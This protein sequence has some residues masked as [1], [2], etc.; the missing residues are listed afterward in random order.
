MA[1][2]LP[3]VF[4]IV[5]G[6][7]F[8]ETLA[9]AVLQGFPNGETTRPLSD[10]TIL[11]PSR[12]AASAFTEILLAKSGKRALILP[13]VKPIGDLDEDRLQDEMMSGDFPEA[14]PALATLL[15]LTRLVKVWATHNPAIHLAQEI[16]ASPVQALNLAR[17]L[18]DIIITAETHHLGASDLAKLYDIDVAEHRQTITSLLELVLK[19]LPSLQVAE[20]KMG[21][22]ARRGAMI[23]A[24]A[25]RIA[26]D[27]HAGPIIAAGS[28]GSI[29][30]TRELL[31]AIA[32]HAE[33]AVIL[34][35]LDQ[36]SDED[37]WKAIKPEHPQFALKTLMA[38]LGIL[39]KDVQ[40]LGPIS[41]P[42]LPLLSEIFRPT[43]TTPEWHKKLPALRDQMAAGLS[44]VTEI[45]SPD[46]HLEARAIAL[47]M[48]ETL[49]HKNKTA[50]LITPDRDL[51]QRVVVELQ[52]WKITVFDS[53]G[54][55][56]VRR[57]LGAA[58]DLFLQV[59]LKEF[60]P[61]A[62][63]A[64]LRHPLVNLG[65]PPETYSRLVE[66]FELAAFRGPVVKLESY[67]A[68]LTQ[69]RSRAENNIHIHPAIKALTPE[70][71][72]ALK[73]LAV[74][75]DHL[76]T[77]SSHH[78]AGIAAQLLA[79]ENALRFAVKPEAWTD[80]SSGVIELLADLKVE[81]HRRPDASVGE[82][83]LLLRQLLQTETQ[84]PAGNGH[85]RLAILGTIEARLLPFEVII[86]GGLN[87]TVWPKGA[88]PG[89]WLNRS[90]REKL[91]LPLPERDLGMAAHDFEQGF[92]AKEIYLTWSKRL[93]HAPQSPS[94]WL[95]R[96][97]AVLVASGVAP[98]EAGDWLALA[99]SL[100]Q[101]GA[102]DPV[103]KPSFAPPLSARPTRFSV[104]EVEKLIRNPYAIYAK[105]ILKLEPLPEF[106]EAPHAGLRGSLFHD[107]IGN[108]NAAQS[109]SLESILAEGEKAL[110]TLG[111][112]EEKRFWLPHFKR[113]AAFLWAEQE[114]LK[115]DLL[116][117]RAELDGKLEFKVAGI[118][119]TL[120][121]R[122]DRIDSLQNNTSRII[123]YKTGSLPSTDQV[124]ANFS[125]Q[126]T[127]ESA[128]LLQGAFGLKPQSIS[129]LIYFKIGGGRE[130]LKKSQAVDGGPDEIAKLAARHLAG[131]KS[132]LSIYQNPAQTYLPRTS[133]EQDDEE[134]D[135]DHLSRYLEWQLAAQK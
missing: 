55:P 58:L 10:W 64:F 107:A 71:W 87:E 4:N 49:E 31:S 110:A 94:R 17:S 8:L 104:T 72:E 52:R 44:G 60:E 30:A 48:R 21:S 74:A 18:S 2:Q 134:Q 42:R 76:I 106:A 22:T 20:G 7:P 117:T 95:L 128:M 93:N 51:A 129:E 81:A 50:A 61:A 70:D 59:R 75:I 85:P 34:P 65:L 80:S 127:L 121:A 112:A 114:V 124:K 119:H 19:D 132:L 102:V 113:L 16:A 83:A 46:R 122:A 77:L 82:T 40:A 12:R 14:M 57:G 24:E 130:G 5:G 78:A 103:Q 131:F 66:L 96:L 116:S 91:N 84:P 67:S 69:A 3:R 53:A 28:T 15:E 108:W 115:Q 73:L 86:L 39:R 120:K 1:R 47:I 11:L 29:P 27:G 92:G 79:I 38:D 105:K 125:P 41:T 111:S 32:H 101:G 23:R 54:E 100:H 33:G 63:F 90:M 13:Q 133:V 109:P 36:F 89:P 68:L 97:K 45:V 6:A 99:Q 25:R 123:D 43:E 26:E 118:A 126:L 62:L 135:Y 56:L 35:G 88:D 37:S 9:D 98:P